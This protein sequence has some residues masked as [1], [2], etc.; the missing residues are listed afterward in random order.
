MKFSTRAVVRLSI[1]L[2]LTAG[3][4]PGAA[5]DP[6]GSTARE[7]ALTCPLLDPLCLVD[8][9]PPKT[10]LD[11]SPSLDRNGRTFSRDAFFKFSTD[12]AE[13][14]ATF[15][16]TLTRDNVVVHEFADCTSNPAPTDGT[17]T[18]ARS[19]T[20]LLD[21]NYVF[22]VR[23]T[24]LADNTETPGAVF[25]WIVG[26]PPP[27]PPDTQ[28]P[29]TSIAEAPRNW[30]LQS[31][32][33]YR[34]TSPDAVASWVCTLDGGDKDCG[35]NGNR[36]IQGL[37][38]GTHEFRVSAVD[39]A[40][41]VDPSPATDTF[42]IPLNSRKLEDYSRG[43][44][45][46]YCQGCFLDRVSTTTKKGAWITQ[47]TKGL[48]KLAL[49]VTKG[50]GYGTVKVY[51]GKVKLRKISLAHDSLRH[52]R[53]VMV[54]KWDTLKSGRIR[55]EVTSSGKTVAIEGIGMAK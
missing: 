44:S 39:Q 48:R 13:P 45:N 1:V 28:A 42:T 43:W 30:N 11:A 2:L 14:G 47:G 46:D 40:G 37:R 53:L 12:P 19:Y 55:I 54:K 20:G 32:A 22:T 36:F 49:V 50:P 31:F 41:N 8:T 5:A 6:G 3:L 21:G 17:S 4:S 29:E 9:T 23:A 26:Y 16:C 52:R 38:A 7:R 51:L 27:P 15:E 34:Y 35:T 25:P 33:Y 10:R 24:D 18:G